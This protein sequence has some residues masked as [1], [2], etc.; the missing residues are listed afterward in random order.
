MQQSDLEEELRKAKFDHLT[1]DELV[2][3]RDKKL[4]KIGLTRAEVHLK[5]CLICEESVELL[6]GELAALENQE[7]TPEQVAVVRR[8]MEQTGLATEPSPAGPAEIAKEFPLQER[9]AEYLGQMAASWRISFGQGALRGEADQGEEVWQWQ[10]KDGKLHARA[11]IQKNADLTIHF[12]SNDMELDG[13]RLNIRLGKLSQET[14]LWR[15]SESEVAAQVAV[16]WP[17][18]QGNMADISIEIV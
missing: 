4:D 3:Y 5:L 6:R 10:S 16:P 7:I 1:A 11:T 9:L 2:A 15:I 8:V 12:S 13:A 18:R 17:Y 14:T